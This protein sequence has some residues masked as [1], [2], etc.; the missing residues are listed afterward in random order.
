MKTLNKENSQ[1]QS[2]SIQINKWYISK[3]KTGKTYGVRVQ[4]ADRQV[5]GEFIDLETYKHLGYGCMLI[6]TINGELSDYYNV[7]RKCYQ[8][9]TGI[10]ASKYVYW[11]ETEEL[12]NHEQ[13]VVFRKGKFI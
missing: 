10:D 13:T 3:S 7:I 8:A 12:I 4:S 1:K 9:V 5:W 11:P 6:D 2:S